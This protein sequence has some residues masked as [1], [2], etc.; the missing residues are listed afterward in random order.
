VAGQPFWHLS[1]NGRLQL[2]DLLVAQALPGRRE[3]LAH[4]HEW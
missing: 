1:G 4:R 3:Q 2:G